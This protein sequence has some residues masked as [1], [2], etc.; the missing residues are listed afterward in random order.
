MAQIPE[1]QYKIVILGNTNV[2]KTCIV[3]R[4]VNDVYM[5]SSQPTIGANFVT[6]RLEMDNCFYKFEV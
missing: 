5:D 4:F 1:F 6:K 2:G 3:H